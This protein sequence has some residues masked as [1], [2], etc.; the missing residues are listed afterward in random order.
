MT[1]AAVE[2]TATVVTVENTTTVVK[3][4]IVMCGV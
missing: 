2:E 1:V 3:F 4:E